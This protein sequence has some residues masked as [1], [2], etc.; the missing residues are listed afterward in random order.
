M[1]KRTCKAAKAA[2]QVRL[3]HKKYGLLVHGSRRNTPMKG[4]DFF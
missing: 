2:K 3:F 1:A 4:T